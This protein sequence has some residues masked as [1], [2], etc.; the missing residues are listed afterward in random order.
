MQNVKLEI[1]RKRSK[2]NRVFVEMWLLTLN[3]AMQDIRRLVYDVDVD[4]DV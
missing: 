1:N 2:M 3:S 4:V